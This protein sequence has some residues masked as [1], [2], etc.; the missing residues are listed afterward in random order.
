[1]KKIVTM[2]VCAAVFTTGCK[3]SAKTASTDAGQS[4]FEPYKQIDLRLPSV[5]LV[6]SDPYF[7]V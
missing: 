1:M 5:P 3:Q 4:F 6:T 7:S 2:I